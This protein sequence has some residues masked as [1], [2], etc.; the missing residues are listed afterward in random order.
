[1]KRLL[2]ALV[3]A[4]VVFGSSL[5]LLLGRADRAA[6]SPA[7]PAAG[8]LAGWWVSSL[9]VITLLRYG[10]QGSPAEGGGAGG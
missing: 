7:Q 5:L 2:G 9:A 1:V 4:A 6:G 8:A 3:L 10:R